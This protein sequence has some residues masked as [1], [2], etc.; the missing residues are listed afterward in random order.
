MIT[1]EDIDK[2]SNLSRIEVSEEEKI[3]FSKEID[4]ILEYVGQISELASES[5]E[6]EQTSSV[7]N[8]FRQ[9][10]NPHESGL[11][12]ETLLKEAP[13]SQDGFVKVKK[14]LSHD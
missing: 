8:V 6:T 5:G 1:P 13:D 4:S 10:E 14:I 12:T 7:R 9:D 2:L 3:S 11:Y